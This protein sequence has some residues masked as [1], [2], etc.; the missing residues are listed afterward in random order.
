M[1]LLTIILLSLLFIFHAFTTAPPREA[2]AAR[3]GRTTSNKPSKAN[4]GQY[5]NAIGMFL[6]VV[7]GCG[8]SAYIAAMGLYEVMFMIEAELSDSLVLSLFLFPILWA[9]FATLFLITDKIRSKAVLI[10]VPS[11]IGA[12]LLY[13]GN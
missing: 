4:R 2:K 12:C 5:L 6:V 11:G 9:T 3:K 13:L 7:F 8:A 10:T 1:G